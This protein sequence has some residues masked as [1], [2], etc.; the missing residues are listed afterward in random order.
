MERG[1]PI[2]AITRGIAVLS[3]INRDGPITMMG[4]SKSADIPYPT[5]CRIVQTFI[6]EGLIEREHA[7][8]RYRATSLV[9]TLS[10]GYQIEDELVSVGRPHIEKLTK[11]LG[12]PVSLASRV[13]TRMMVR[14][15]THKMTSLTF[16]NYYPGYT[17]PI[18]ECATGKVYLA[19]CSDEER[20]TVIEGWKATESE[21]SQA[22]LLLL[23]DNEI[24]D[25]IRRSGFSCQQRN[26]Y[27]AEPGKTSA[28][29]VP[30]MGKDGA[31]ISGLGIIYFDA[32]L[33][34]EEAAKQFLPYL[35]NTAQAISADMH[36]G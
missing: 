1:L 11:E 23:R 21:T 28:V 20:E 4:I 36:D 13:G 35:K 7:R 9:K 16:T 22:G 33:K 10:A 34:P 3:A 18:A 8:K 27:N 6:H 15:S 5:A 24:L 30:V 19:F 14:D 29:A 32:A 31:I 12:W 25:R 26:F 17:L 2:R